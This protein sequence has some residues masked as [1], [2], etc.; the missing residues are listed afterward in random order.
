MIFDPKKKEKI[1]S[2]KSAR[3]AEQRTLD[4]LFPLSSCEDEALVSSDIFVVIRIV[5]V[6]ISHLE[7]L[8]E[9]QT[10]NMDEFRLP[11]C[12]SFCSFLHDAVR[13][14]MMMS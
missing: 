5:C 3:R 9:R 12:F 14:L 13:L 8:K 10:I 1:R 2:E 11:S 7:E 4:F 6:L